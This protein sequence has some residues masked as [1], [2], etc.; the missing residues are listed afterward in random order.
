[1]KA[2]IRTCAVG[3]QTTS[4]DMA[5]SAPEGQKSQ[6]EVWSS[7]KESKMPWRG[8]TAYLENCCALSPEADADT[9]KRPEITRAER[10]VFAPWQTDLHTVQREDAPFVP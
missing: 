5:A 3:N 10:P 2:P 9:R 1:M 6:R 8:S 7:T 4:D